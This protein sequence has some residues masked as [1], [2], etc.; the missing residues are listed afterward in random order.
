MRGMPG[1]RGGRSAAGLAAGISNGAFNIRTG[2][3]AYFDTTTHHITADHSIAS[4][5][6]P[7]SFPTTE[8]ESEHYWAGSIVSKMPLA[9]SRVAQNP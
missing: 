7:P 9:R 4:G 5:S 3:F 2:N 1:T 6:L 8:I